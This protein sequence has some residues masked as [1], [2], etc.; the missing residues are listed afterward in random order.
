MNVSILADS[1]GSMANIADDMSGSLNTLMEENRNLP[2][3]V[4]VTY[5]IFS[6]TYMPQFTEMPIRNVPPFKIV[7]SNTTALLESAC[8]MINEVDARFAAMPEYPEKVMFVI[9]TDGMENAS[10]PEYTRTRLFSLIRRQTEKRN[11]VFLYFGA[12]QDAIQEAESFGI[13][14]D[15]AVNWCA[16][17]EGV[18]RNTARVS[19]KMKQMEAME[20]NLLQEIAFDDEDRQ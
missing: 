6:D 18:R 2:T 10:A 4:T 13:S 12:N 16:N 14:G 19:R 8:K 17:T 9:V 7:P 1:S 20:V 15:K 11:W 5:S 3:E